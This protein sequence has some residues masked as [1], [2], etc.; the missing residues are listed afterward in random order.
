[1]DDKNT[2]ILFEKDLKFLRENSVYGVTGQY[3]SEDFDEM[4][5]EYD[6]VLIEPLKCFFDKRGIWKPSITLFIM[7]EYDEQTYSF[8]YKLIC[9]LCENDGKDLDYLDMNK[10]SMEYMI[11]HSDQYNHGLIINANSYNGEDSNKIMEGHWIY[12]KS[13]IK[14]SACRNSICRTI[15]FRD[16][17]SLVYKNKILGFCIS[18]ADITPT[19]MTYESNTI[20]YV[21]KINV[22]TYI[23]SLTK[24]RTDSVYNHA[25]ISYDEGQNKFIYIEPH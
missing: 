11:D 17:T 13:G 15:L 7:N 4:E 14:L 16:F 19:S 18:S 10:A 8:I 25:I 2:D 12:Q 1:M 23:L 6:K 24:S 21:T 22:D 5:Y 3:K 20:I 9:D